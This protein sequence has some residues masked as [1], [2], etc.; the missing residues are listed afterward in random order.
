MCYDALLRVLAVGAVFNTSGTR[1]AS[2]QHLRQL[3]GIASESLAHSHEQ[4]I[5]TIG[6]CFVVFQTKIVL[7]SGFIRA[8]CVAWI[9]LCCSWLSACGRMRSRGMHAKTHNFSSK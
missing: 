4:T 5:V 1:D 9:E 8:A 3:S 2:R 7:D 6:A